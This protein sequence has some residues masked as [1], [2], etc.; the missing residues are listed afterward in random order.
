MPSRHCRGSP[1]IFHRETKFGAVSTVE[2]VPA[3][4]CALTSGCLRF[5]NECACTSDILVFEPSHDEVL[6]AVAC[7]AR[8]LGLASRS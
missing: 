1:A 8:A 7:A 4:D 2:W 5:L 3:G 6:I